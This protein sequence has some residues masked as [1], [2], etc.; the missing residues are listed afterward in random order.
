MARVFDCFSALFPFG[1]Q[2]DA[3]LTARQVDRTPEEIQRRALS[4]LEE[5][6]A[7]A[8]AAGVPAEWIESS[9]F[10]LIA[11]IDEIIA[12]HSDWAQAIVPLQMQLF[13]STNA[14]SEFF[15]HL[16]A[17][18]PEEAEVREVYW[19]VLVFGFK[20][21][22]Y[23]ETGKTGELAKLKELHAQQLPV[24]PLDPDALADDPI[25]PEPYGTPDPPGPRRPE[26][27]TRALLRMG[28]ALALLAPMLA[29]LWLMLAGPRESPPTLAQRVEQ[30]LQGYACAD[31]TATAAADGSLRVQGFVSLPEDMARVEREVRA[32]PGVTSANFDMSLRQWPHCEVVAMLKPYRAR[33]REQRRGL[34][35]VALTAQAGKLREGDPVL[36]QIT[37]ADRDGYLRVDYYTADG[38]V[39]HLR[40]GRDA[41]GVRGG[42]VIEI[43]G[44]IPS[45]WLVNPPFGTVMLTVM[46]SPTSFGDV[47]ERP[48]FELA[49]AYLGRL[50]ESLAAKESSDQLT[51]DYIFLDT[52]E[53]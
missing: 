39:M 29:W 32:E 1:L 25:T 23:F 52:V 44:D 45:S 34:K 47:T 43:G 49:S 35:I 7:S 33:N 26:R 31:L 8:R 6:R 2:L 9:S 36:M 19:H 46:S 14:P 22:Y 16:A 28:G 13:N 3:S 5:A 21:Q 30:R 20:G 24:R 17:L 27:R 10:A 42:E 51:A 4:L 38:S 41:A 53:R 11:W 18:Q 15:H 50:R 12:R 48:P 37:N 40:G